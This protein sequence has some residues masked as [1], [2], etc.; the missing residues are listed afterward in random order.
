MALM[1]RGIWQDSD[2]GEELCER[3][4]AVFANWASEKWPTLNIPTTPGKTGTAATRRGSNAELEYSASAA[5]DPAGGILAACRHDLVESWEDGSR[6][7]TTLRSWRHQEDSTTLLNWI[8]VDVEAVGGDVSQIDPVAPGF[9]TDLL[10][11]GGASTVGGDEL[12]PGA[13]KVSGFRQ[14]DELAE[15]ISRA[16]RTLPLIVINGG[17]KAHGEA[18]QHG[19]KFSEIVDI[20]RRTTA[21]IAAVYTVDDAAA[22]GIIAGLGKSHGVWDGAMRIYLPEV[23]PAAPGNAWRHRYFTAIRYARSKNVARRT[24]GRLLGPVS[25]VRRPPSSYPTVKSLLERRSADGDFEALLSIADADLKEADQT[26]ADLREDVRER[27][28]S[29]D[30]LSVDLAIAAS[31]QAELLERLE[32][33]DRHVKSLQSQLTSADTFYMDGGFQQ[34]MPATVDSPSEAAEFAKRFLSDR[35]VIPAAALRDLDD[36][37]AAPTAVAWGQTAWKGFRALHAYAQDRASGWASG[38]FW[39]WCERSQNSRAWPASAKKL[40]MSESES[41]NNSRRLRTLREFPVDSELDP[42]GKLYMQAHLKIA[43]GGGNLAPRIYFFCDDERCR[44]HIGFFGP[45]RLLP[46]TRS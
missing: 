21:G 10:N 42:S 29:I 25:A 27:D 34:T 23:D 33:L 46:N 45:H 14:G 1:Y 19:L 39:E 43:E 24:V 15:V 22:D 26:I 36:L 12:L 8:W 31:E 41:V 6:W 2:F 20:V 28:E 17:E 18:E 35:L 38:G 4:G 9:I 7:H 40:A 13:A 44:V 11:A 37:D 30:G 3:T 5:S 16:D 32:D